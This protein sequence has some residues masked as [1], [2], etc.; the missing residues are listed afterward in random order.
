MDVS[1]ARSSSEQVAIA[2]PAAFIGHSWPA[3]NREGNGSPEMFHD[4]SVGSESRLSRW[5]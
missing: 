1:E 3:I 4:G 2:E 5:S